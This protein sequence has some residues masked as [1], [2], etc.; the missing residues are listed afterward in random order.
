MLS[1]PP[2]D[3]PRRA[4]YGPGHG[5]LVV[6]SLL[7]VVL[8]MTAHDETRASSCGF[9]ATQSVATSLRTGSLCS[10]ESDPAAIQQCRRRPR[11]AP[12]ARVL[13]MNR[14][15]QARDVP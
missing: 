2:L 8:P 11:H 1:P 7:L 12:L 13:G 10:S 3:A 9:R 5:L 4:R 6:V 14:R 15:P